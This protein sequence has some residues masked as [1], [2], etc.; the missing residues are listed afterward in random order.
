MSKPTAD[1]ARC[2]E[3]GRAVV[4]QPVSAGAAGNWRLQGFI[5]GWQEGR[6]VLLDARD[7]AV[8]TFVR[9]EM[10][11]TVRF[12]FQ[13]TACGFRATI[14]DL[15]PGTFIR[16]T[17]PAE[18]SFAQVR[19]HERVEVAIPCTAGVEG[20]EPAQASI[21]DLSLGGCRVETH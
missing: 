7:D 4:I 3:V 14:L 12:L 9:S 15:G 11:C 18:M 10:A 13:G 17:W 20:A 2:L 16:V 19:R 6:Y 5:R 21:T 1:I 8:P